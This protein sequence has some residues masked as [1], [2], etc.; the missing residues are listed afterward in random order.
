MVVYL[1]MVRSCLRELILIFQGCFMVCSWGKD[2][3]LEKRC[4]LLSLLPFLQG[5]VVRSL[6]S[7]GKRENGLW[8]KSYWFSLQIEPKGPFARQRNPGWSTVWTSQPSANILP[9]GLTFK[10]FL[11][12]V[13][14][15]KK[16]K[17]RK[18]KLF[19][20]GKLGN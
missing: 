8:V 18:F 15:V 5:F 20:L 14:P 6:L 7:L 3:R 17:T 10:L 11:W 4:F 1:V 13:F 12:L 9:Q 2:I 16:T 19:V